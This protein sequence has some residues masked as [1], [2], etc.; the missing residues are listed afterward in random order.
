MNTIE[1]GILGAGNIG[2]A[3]AR[4]L[5][6][7]GHRLQLANRSGPAS[8]KALVDELGP[9][10]T[11]STPQEVSRLNIVLVAIPWTELAAAMSGLPSWGGRIV[12]DANN[13]VTGFD[14]KQFQFA[15]LGGRTSS[16]VFSRMVPEARV[17]KA[18]NTL[19]AAVLSEDPRVGNGRRV[20][21]VSGDEALSKKTVIDLV[22]NVGF[23]PIDLGSLATGGRL[24]QAGG[25]LAA[26]NLVRMP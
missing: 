22:E 8:L 6:K 16:E 26:M 11:A 12:V 9:N 13:H 14:G 24:Q 23:S 21:F 1:I 3:F 15:D 17:V 19:P 2:R 7:V 25:P 18:L 20:V 10:A 5:V 4:Q